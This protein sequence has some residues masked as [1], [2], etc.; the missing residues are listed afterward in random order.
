M[1]R[2]RGSSWF[3]QL[4]VGVKTRRLDRAREGVG[5]RVLVGSVCAEAIGDADDRVAAEGEVGGGGDGGIAGVCDVRWVIDEGAILGAQAPVP[6]DGVLCTDAD[7]GRGA[8]GAVGGC[9]GRGDVVVVIAEVEEAGSG[10]DG[11]G[12]AAM[13]RALRYVGC[14]DLIDVLTDVR[15]LSS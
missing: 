3:P 11:G 8:V 15:P 10:F 13:V 5:A 1:G 4:V 12:E 6:G 7:D 14:G 2:G 9:R